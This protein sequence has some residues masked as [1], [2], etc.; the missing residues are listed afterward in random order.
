VQVAIHRVARSGRRG[1]ARGGRGATRPPGRRC[2]GRPERCPSA[3]PGRAR[4]LFYAASTAKGVAWRWRTCSSSGVTSTTTCGLPMSGPS[5]ACTARSSCAAPCA[6]PYGGRAGAALR[7]DRRG[8][9]QLGAH[10]RRARGRRAMVGARHAVRLPRQTFGS[11]S[12]RSS[13]GPRAGSCRGGAARHDPPRDRGP[14]A[15]WRPRGAAGLRGTPTQRDWTTAGLRNPGR[16]PTG[17]SL[18]PSGPT[19]T[20]PTAATSSPSASSRAAP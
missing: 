16:R 1:W 3:A 18:R 6:A 8:P 17:R 11:C 13:V 9:V 2:C 19:R 7:H 10:V 15:L 14:G 20:S 5:L 4:H 12:A